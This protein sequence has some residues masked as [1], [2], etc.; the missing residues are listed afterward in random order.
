MG[1]GVGASEEAA[2]DKEDDDDVIVDVDVNAIDVNEVGSFSSACAADAMVT[3]I[4]GV[5]V[6][7]KIDDCVSVSDDAVDESMV[8]LKFVEDGAGVN[9]VA[10]VCE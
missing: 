2:V 3:V 9:V 7:V 1:N 5:D 6:D 8:G 10:D 4:V